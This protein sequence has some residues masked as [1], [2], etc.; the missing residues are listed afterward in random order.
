MTL[1][2]LYVTLKTE[3]IYYFLLGDVKNMVTITFREF[4]SY[5]NELGHNLFI[6][7]LQRIDNI[8]LLI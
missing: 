7:N 4:D 5:I 1:G 2:C 3:N 8:E 6:A